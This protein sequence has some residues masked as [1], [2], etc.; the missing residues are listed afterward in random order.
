[1]GSTSS[2]KF[3]DYP[4]SREK[5]AGGGG[6]GTGGAGGEDQCSRALSNVGLE[7]V[8]RSAYFEANRGVPAAGT[9]VLL[10]STL[11]GPRLSVDTTDGQSIGFLPTA[12]NYLAVC[13]KKGFAY[14]GEVTSSSGGSTPAVRVNLQATRR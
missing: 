5:G 1:M 2:G 6:G 12:Y 10:R 4:P 3:K 14:S 11:V 7:E 8:G 13:M 9:A